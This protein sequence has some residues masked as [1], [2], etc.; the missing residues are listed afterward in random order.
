MG[1][2]NIQKYKEAIAY[3]EQGLS[4][5]KTS[6]KLGLPS[7]TVRTWLWLWN[8]DAPSRS[9]ILTEKD[10]FRQVLDERLLAKRKVSV[11]GKELEEIT[12]IKST[13]VGGIPQFAK[14][15]DFLIKTVEN[16]INFTPRGA[17]EDYDKMEA[18]SA[19][20][21]T[22]YNLTFRK[23]ELNRDNDEEGDI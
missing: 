2:K 6:I 16:R 1:K 12:F 3:F 20:F 11:D 14:V 23:A 10:E 17:P 18:A 4:G 8:K 7:G 5:H 19:E 21:M 22:W 15:R 9:K 13:P